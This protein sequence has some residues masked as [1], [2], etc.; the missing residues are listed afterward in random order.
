MTRVHMTFNRQARVIETGGCTVEVK[1]PNDMRE[2][3]QKTEA[4][5]FVEFLVAD[6]DYDEEDW[7]FE[8]L[9]EE[10]DVA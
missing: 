3:R 4:R 2:I 6:R 9:D 7:E 5:D 1:D 10:E 8:I